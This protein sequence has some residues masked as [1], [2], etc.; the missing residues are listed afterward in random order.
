MNTTIAIAYDFDGTLAPGN[1][2]EHSFIQDL[3]MKPDKFWELSKRTAKKN[4]MDEILA[5]MQLILKKAGEKNLPV[6]ES[7]FKQYGKKVN[8]FDG[9]KTWFERI[10]K[11]AKSKK[12]IVEHYIISSGLREI[13]K[14]TAIFNEFK[15]VF[16]SGYQY[17][18]SGEAEYPALAVNYTTKTQY[19]FRINKGIHNSWDN[20]KINKFQLENE[21]YIPFKRIIFIGDGETDIPAMKIVRSQGGHS[22]AVY[23]K[24]AKKRNTHESV[25]KLVKDRRAN[26]CAEANY[27]EN[28]EIDKIVKMIIDKIAIDI[29]LNKNYTK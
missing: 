4:D 25:K 14:G 2:Q 10:N 6:R 26:F 12:I 13:I 16:A 21:R 9:V 20:S 3:K 15:Y 23:K 7:D 22:I 11:Y 28:F 17:S 18:P 29:E 27:K 19:L 8:L 5:Y 24:K 1:M